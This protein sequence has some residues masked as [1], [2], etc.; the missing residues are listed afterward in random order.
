M[1]KDAMDKLLE[2]NEMKRGSEV[3][4]VKNSGHQLCIDNP[5]GCT[6]SVVG[7]VFG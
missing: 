2:N 6:A 4:T 7:F 3:N 5:I 1:A